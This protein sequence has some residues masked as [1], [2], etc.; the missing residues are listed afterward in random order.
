MEGTRYDLAINTTGINDTDEGQLVPYMVIIDSRYRDNADKTEPGHYTITL[1]KPY[2][3]VTSLELVYCDIPASNYNVVEGVNDKLHFTI[4]GGS[5]IVATINPGLYTLDPVGGN[6]NISIRH[7]ITNALNLATDQHT[8]FG[9]TAFN[10]SSI[11]AVNPF[12]LN[13]GVLSVTCMHPF[14]FNFDGG[15]QCGQRVYSSGSIAQLL[16]FKPSNYSSSS[17]NAVQTIVATYPPSLQMDQYITLHIEGMSRI[18]SG[19]SFVQDAFCVVPVNPCAPTFGLLKC[20]NVVDNEEYRYYCVTPRK[21][22]RLEIWFTDTRG[23]AYNFRG[24]DHILAFRVTSLACRQKCR[25]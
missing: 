14:T 18:D 4:G 23:N 7:A 13:V 20:C 8:A 16:G 9:T 19:T 11:N 2:R 12:N 10:L 24:Q 17:I 25:I 3:D 1:Q 15:V 22:N 5:P 6:N 21:L